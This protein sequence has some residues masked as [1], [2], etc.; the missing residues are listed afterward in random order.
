ME[1]RISIDSPIGM[2]LKGH[3]VGDRWKLRSMTITAIFLK[4]VPLTRH[5]PRRKKSEDF[6]F[7]ESPRFAA[8]NHVNA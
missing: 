4:S 1:N 7:A 2:A 6:N 8:R 5:I 3:K